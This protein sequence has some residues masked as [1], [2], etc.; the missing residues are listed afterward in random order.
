MTHP[1]LRLNRVILYVRDMAA[2][3]S[4]YRDKLGFP[5]I[6]PDGAA[7]LGR[8]PFVMLDAGPCA[9]ALH[10]GGQGRPVEGVPNG[11]MTGRAPASQELHSRIREPCRE[12]SP[13]CRGMPTRGRLPTN[14]NTKKEK[15]E[16]R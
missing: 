10:C 2:Q 5:V 4:F 6:Y 9:L 7:D 3:I 1:E 15:E 14:A 8:E 13:G 16:I 11:A 12:P